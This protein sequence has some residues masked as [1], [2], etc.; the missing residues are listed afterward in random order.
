AA[1]D[2]AA[3][4]SPDKDWNPDL[5]L[6]SVAG[7]MNK[8]KAQDLAKQ[9]LQTGLT[10]PKADEII[11]QL[12]ALGHNNDGINKLL[13]EASATAAE[14]P[15]KTK[16]GGLWKIAPGASAGDDKANAAF[17]ADHVLGKKTVAGQSYRQM[18]G[19][20]VKNAG[21]LGLA[22]DK[23]AALKTKLA[24]AWGLAYKQL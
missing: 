13:S 24:E 8:I 9:L 3:A 22:P 2:I 18:L 5:A 11:E 1:L 10:G 16:F 7:E 23:V 4:T 15:K 6:A 12:Y 20:L 14:A 21:D 17:T 19:Y